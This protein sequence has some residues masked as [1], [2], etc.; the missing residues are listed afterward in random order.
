MLGIEPVPPISDIAKDK[1][2]QPKEI[3]K[4]EFE[5]VWVEYFARS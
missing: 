5:R 2:F 4:A 3:T 1:Q